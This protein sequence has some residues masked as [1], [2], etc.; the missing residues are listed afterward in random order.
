MQASRPAQSRKTCVSWIIPLALKL[1]LEC[2][3]HPLTLSSPGFD[4]PEITCWKS[5]NW[6]VFLL[7]FTER[8]KWNNV[9]SA[10]GVLSKGEPVM[11]YVP[12]KASL[13]LAV[14]CQSQVEVLIAGWCLASKMK[15]VRVKFLK[16]K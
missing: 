12:Q 5:N 3:V 16:F 8:H 13:Y 1:A 6:K 14:S 11:E 9:P 10:W 7:P 15:V 2:R 4:G